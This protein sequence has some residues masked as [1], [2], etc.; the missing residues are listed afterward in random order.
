MAEEENENE[1]LEEEDDE[2][3]GEASRDKRVETVDSMLEKEPS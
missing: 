3:E 2:E 1:E